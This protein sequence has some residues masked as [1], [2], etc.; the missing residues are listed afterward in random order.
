[1]AIETFSPLSAHAEPTKY[2][3][4]FR[5]SAHDVLVEFETQHSHS[6]GLGIAIPVCN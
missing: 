3:M 1:M 2:L 6:L 4:I 5:I